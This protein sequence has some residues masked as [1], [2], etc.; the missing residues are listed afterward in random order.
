M[1]NSNLIYFPNQEKLKK[2]EEKGVYFTKPRLVTF[3]DYN[4]GKIT[5]AKRINYYK[6]PTDEQYPLDLNVDLLSYRRREPEMYS[7]HIDL[8]LKYCMSSSTKNPNDME[9]V[10]KTKVITRRGTL[11]AIME[12]YY[13]RFNV[14]LIVR[15]SRYNGNL[16]MVKEEYDGSKEELKSA[17]TH[18]RRL[19]QLLFS[20]KIFSKF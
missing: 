12:Y 3:L 2:Y 13:S 18:H 7:K 1:K 16:Y 15:V 14:D 8:S 10:E 17:H 11:V 20:G 5:H 4:Y 9:N 19:D 6:K